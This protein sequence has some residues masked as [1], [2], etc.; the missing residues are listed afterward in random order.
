MNSIGVCPFYYSL[1]FGLNNEI[2]FIQFVPSLK[3]YCFCS[4]KKN[5]KNTFILYLILDDAF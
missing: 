2:N 1:W 4:Q 5:K 3:L